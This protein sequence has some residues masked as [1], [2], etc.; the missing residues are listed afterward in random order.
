LSKVNLP[1]VSIDVQQVVEL[2]L[3]LSKSEEKAKNEIKEFVSK[4]EKVYNT[5]VDSVISFYHIT[6]EERFKSQFAIQ[7][8]NFK[9][10]FL[11]YEISI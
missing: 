7:Y 10:Y 2:A 1:G 3:K 9:K 6:D 4:V 11:G 5:F 8:T